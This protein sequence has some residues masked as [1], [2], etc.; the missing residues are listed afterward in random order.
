MTGET[1]IDRL[2]QRMQPALN[3]GAYVFCSL[4]LG[5]IPAEVQP[6]GLF[7]E[8]EGITVILP[9]A[10]ADRFG[11]HYS[12][13]AAWITLTIHSS[14]E[15][16]GLTAA[17]SQALANAGISC[18]VIAAFYHDHLFVSW[19]DGDRAMAVLRRLSQS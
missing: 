19:K 9:Q 18:N 8:A 15:A 13:V 5:E 7:Q 14:L 12:F 11:M 6:I 2:I 10:E 17:V 4:K 16:V 3:P 1:A